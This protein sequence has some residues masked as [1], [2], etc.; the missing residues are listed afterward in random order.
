MNSPSKQRDIERHRDVELFLSRIGVAFGSL[1]PSTQTCLL[2][3][4]RDARAIQ[5]QP[6]ANFGNVVLKLCMAVESELAAGLGQIPKLQFLKDGAL[7]KKAEFLRKTE[8]DNQTKQRLRVWKIKPGFVRSELPRLLSSLA[9]LRRE[10]GAA[11]G[12]ETLLFATLEDAENASSLTRQILQG[13]KR[14]AAS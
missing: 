14:K 1:A 12:N 9:K 6:S 7:G 4:A 13:I 2:N 10:S 8:L 5:D 3:W 11:H